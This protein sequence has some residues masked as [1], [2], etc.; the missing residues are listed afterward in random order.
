MTST[1]KLLIG[2]TGG[3]GSGKT[4]VAD[5]FAERGAT[6]IDTDVISR[7]LTDSDGA[8]VAAVRLAFGDEMINAQ[9]AMD[10]VKMRAFAFSD[11]VQKTRLESIL[12]PL[13]YDEAMRQ[14]MNATGL[15]VMCVVPL[16]VETGRWQSK[17]ARTLVVDCDEELQVQRVMQR[18][19]LSEQLVKAI[20]AQ[21]VTR[22]ERLAV[23]TDVL[24]NQTTVQAL[25]PEIDRLHR[26]YCQIA[27]ENREC[28]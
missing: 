14:T 8:A 27:S 2:L 16:L 13:I 3:I 18:D 19:G 15:Y 4:R 22:A 28:L 12:H 9:G 26:L 1:K 23:A 7:E 11:A 6:V 24:Q 25:T 10:R 5:A 17:L 20:M 21:Q